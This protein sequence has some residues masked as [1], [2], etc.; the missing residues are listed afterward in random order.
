[1]VV[2]DEEKNGLF[3]V[4]IEPP[5]RKVEIAPVGSIK[6]LL[7]WI[8]FGIFPFPRC[9][10]GAS[11]AKRAIQIMPIVDFRLGSACAMPTVM[12]TTTAIMPI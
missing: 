5:G 1:M 7:A 12:Q 9:S 8:V 6:E 2:I 4:W 3:L 10:S 11:F